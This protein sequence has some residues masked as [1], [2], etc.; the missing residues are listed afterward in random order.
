MIHASAQK[1]VIA[2]VPVHILGWAYD[3]LVY[4]IK[5]IIHIALIQSFFLLIKTILDVIKICLI[6]FV[7]VVVNIKVVNSGYLFHFSKIFSDWISIC[8]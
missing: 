6:S 2:G 7:F 8:R 1:A 4:I 5:I 3:M